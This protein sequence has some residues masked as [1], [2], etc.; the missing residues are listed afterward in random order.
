VDELEYQRQRAKDFEQALGDAL[1]TLQVV[2]RCASER[3]AEI[4]GPTTTYEDAFRKLE[5]ACAALR[6][7]EGEAARALG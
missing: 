7:I 4:V 6:F 2:R 1:E 5:L 3:R